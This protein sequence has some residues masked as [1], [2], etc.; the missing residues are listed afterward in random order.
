MRRNLSGSA[1]TASKQSRAPLIE[2]EPEVER[3]SMYNG[4]TCCVLTAGALTSGLRNRESR[5]SVT[6]KIADPSVS[7]HSSQPQTST[8]Q[9]KRKT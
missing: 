2:A 8:A 7:V 4:A 9:E 5:K 6:Y 1:A 3:L